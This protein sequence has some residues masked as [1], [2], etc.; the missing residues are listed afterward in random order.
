MA[1]IRR[2]LFVAIF[3]KSPCDLYKST[4]GPKRIDGIRL[5]VL[6]TSTAWLDSKYAS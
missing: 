2:Y 3:L 5:S 1:Q 6:K 4:R